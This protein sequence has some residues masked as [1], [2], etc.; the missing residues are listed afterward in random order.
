MFSSQT[1]HLKYVAS[2]KNVLF[3]SWTRIYPPDILIIIIYQIIVSLNAKVTIQTD[4]Y[5]DN[6]SNSRNYMR[7]DTE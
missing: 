1:I 6:D 4:V 3:Y 5:S 7:E 2:I